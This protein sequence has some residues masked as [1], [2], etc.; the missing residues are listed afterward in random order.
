MRE[1][2]RSKKRERERRRTDG[3]TA[4][5]QRAQREG[6]AD[7]KHRMRTVISVN[8][9]ICENNMGASH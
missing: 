5:S 1:R 8:A 4:G 2:K 7:D 6:E 9:H 3:V